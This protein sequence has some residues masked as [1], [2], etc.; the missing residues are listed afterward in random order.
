MVNPSATAFFISE[1][2]VL[3][4]PVRPVGPIWSIGSYSKIIEERI[5][6]EVI[7]AIIRVSMPAVRFIRIIAVTTM[8]F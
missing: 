2:A 8:D 5:R 6:P 1:I 4:S 3:I 7:V